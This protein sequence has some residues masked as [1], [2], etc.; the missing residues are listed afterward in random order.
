MDGARTASWLVRLAQ[1][2]YPPP[3]GRDGRPPRY[4]MCTPHVS[5]R[6]GPARR[7]AVGLPPHCRMAELGHAPLG[8]ALSGRTLHGHDLRTATT[9][10]ASASAVVG[11]WPAP[12]PDLVASLLRSLKRERTWRLV[13]RLHQ[14]HQALLEP[15]SGEGGGAHDLPGLRAAQRLLQAKEGLDLLW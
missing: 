14:P 11:C 3:P 13:Q 7:G 6:H 5:A 15:I 12:L 10:S 2:G 9:P 1:A 4:A 8:H